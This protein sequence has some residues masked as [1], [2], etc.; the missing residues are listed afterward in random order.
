MKKATTTLF[1]QLVGMM[2]RS[3]LEGIAAQFYKPGNASKFT[4][5]DQLVALVFCHIGGCDSL[6]EIEDGLYSALGSLNHAGGAQ[7]LKRTS[8]A[9]AN[10][11]RD[12]RIFEQFY[13]KLLEHYAD[14]F[15]LR[16]SSKY[17]KPVYA[18]DSTTITLCMKLFPWAKY[19]SSTCP[20]TRSVNFAT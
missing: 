11:R 14:L 16:F 2:P 19:T 8:L 7:A 10:A 18:I 3:I 15:N 12:Y 5:W 20:K 6:R 4:V 17:D 1:A 9:Y 13:F